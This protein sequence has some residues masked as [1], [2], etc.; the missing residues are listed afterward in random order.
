MK[1]FQI[2]AVA[3]AMS[4]LILGCNKFLDLDPEFTQDAENYFANEE[5][6]DRALTGAY[7]LLQTSYLTLWLGEIASD[8]A[9]AGGESV[10][11]TE[12]LHEID[13]MRHDAVN[14]ELRSLMRYN[15]AGVTRANFLLENKDNIDFEGKSKIIGQARF[16][17]AYYYFELV[18]CFGDVPLILD[19][20][21]GAQ[22]VTE[23]ERTPK[24]EVYA[25]IEEDLK[26]A[27]D[28]LD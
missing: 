17:R 15:Y 23:L 21:I 12:G 28:T 13:E 25:A 22:A 9:I 10:T 16:L 3:G 20:R 26:F 5:D 4:L 6:Y 18:K 8:N 11:D 1:T 14:T 24:A 27:A 7:D 2:F 19:E